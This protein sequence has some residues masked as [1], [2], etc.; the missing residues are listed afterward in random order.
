MLGLSV[1]NYHVAR[2]CYYSCH[3][4]FRKKIP[5]LNKEKLSAEENI[6]NFRH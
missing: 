1:I 4:T 2:F 5:N 6:S 3:L